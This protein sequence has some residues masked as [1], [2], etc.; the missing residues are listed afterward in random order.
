M[1]FV[2][3]LWGHENYY[4]FKQRPDVTSKAEKLVEGLLSAVMGNEVLRAL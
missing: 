1:W 2:S 4:E 3:G